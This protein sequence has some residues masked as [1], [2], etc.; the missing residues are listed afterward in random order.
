VTSSG[1]TKRA[2]YHDDSTNVSMVSVSRLASPP[3]R[4]HFARTNDSLLASGDPPSPVNGTSSGSTTGRSF[5]GTG[6][7]PSR[8]Q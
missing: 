4:G 5:A 3:Q 1:Q 7:T 8:S 2:K 6:T